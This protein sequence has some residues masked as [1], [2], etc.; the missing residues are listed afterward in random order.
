MNIYLGTIKNKI[1]DH[2]KRDGGRIFLENYFGSKLFGYFTKPE[3]KNNHIVSN[4]CLA[5]FFFLEINLFFFCTVS[6]AFFLCIR[7][8]L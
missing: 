4:R 7:Q 2:K 6:M 8:I 5:L 3:L 1:L